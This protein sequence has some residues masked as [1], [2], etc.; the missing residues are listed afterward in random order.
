MVVGTVSNEIVSPVPASRLWKALVKD[1]P[2]LMPK[3][4]PDLISKIVVLE[5]DGGVGTIVHT[6]FNPGAV[7]DLSYWK[8]RVDAIDDEK[9]LFR[10]SIIEGGLIGKKVKSTSF[11]LKFEANNPD[12]ATTCKLNG[13][14]DTIADTLPPEEEK[15]E[16]VGGMVGMFK[17]VEGYLLANPEAYA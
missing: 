10:Y 6:D 12:G 11:E 2:A 16:M 4:L 15:K 9:Y 3:I 5:G 7:K 14:F 17:A 13:E 1:S 8:H